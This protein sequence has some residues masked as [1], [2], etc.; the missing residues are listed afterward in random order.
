[1][2]IP[3]Q[4]PPGVYRNGTQ[5]QS[6][7][8]YIEA[9]LVRWYDSTLRPIG[10]W[11]PRNTETVTGKA[12]GLIAWRDNAGDRWL[13]VGTHSKLF[14]SGITDTVKEITPSGYTVGNADATIKLGYGFGVY[15]TAQYGIT[16]PDIGLYQPATTWSLDTW[17]EYLVACANT[18]GKI[19]EWQLG[20]STPTVAAQVANSP[21]NCESI[22]VTDER[23]LFAL[24]ADNNPRKVQWCDQEDNTEW[25]PSTLNQAGDFELTTVGT[26]Q[27]GKRFRGSTL[28]FTDVDIHVATYIGPPYVYS[29]ERAG[30]GCGVISK[31]SVG[32]TD[33]S[34]IWMAKN[35]FWYYD[36]FVKP[37]PSDVGDYVFSD[38]NLVQASKIYCVHNSAFGEM[39]WFYP[40]ESSNE[41]DSYVTFNYRENHWNIGKMARTCG[42]D[43]GVFANPIMVGT[44]GTIYEHE[45]G[46]I[47]D[48]RLP[49]A[50]SGPIEIAVGDR[51]VSVTGMVPDERTQGQVQARF[52]TQFYPNSSE[53]NYG[54]YSMANPT[55]VRLTGR[56]I[57]VRFEGVANADWRIGLPR[58]DVVLGGKR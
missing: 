13:V 38:I 21:E 44:D 50:E 7:G 5:Y 15:G 45:I 26:L 54:P 28:L 47:Y 35:G 48:G 39:W 10:G 2:Y 57:A 11:R 1:M 32:V 4:L 8:R 51:V 41:V 36:G 18:D 58:L 55:S 52:A 17:G 20:Y 19:Y 9:D 3:L 46:H 34:V 42:T 33:N 23:F 29:F 49:Y 37:L 30:T 40:S 27:C 22:I 31:Q 24:G 43:A 6:K 56:Q 25:T 53:F 12:R 14:V 16:R